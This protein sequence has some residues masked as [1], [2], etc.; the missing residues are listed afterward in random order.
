MPGKEDLMF[1]KT[2]YGVIRYSSIN[3]GDEIQSLAQMRFLPQID[4]YVA[5]EC[6]NEFKPE[7]ENERVKL[8]M[9]AW[10]MWRYKNFPPSEYIDP[11]FVSFHLREAIRHKFL[12]PDTLEYLKKHAP[13][14]CRDTGTVEY[15]KENGIDAYFTGCLT[16]TLLPNQNLKGK[17]TS[18]YVICVDCPDEIVKMVRHRTDRPVYEF[19]RMLSPAFTSIDRFRLAKFALFLYHNAYCV[20][21]P[22]LHVALPSIAFGVPVCVI[23][24]DLLKRNGR[25]D[26]LEGLCNEVDAA[27][28]MLSKSA[29]D[30]DNPPAN[31][32]AY[33]DMRAN[34][35]AKCREFTKFDSEKSPLEDDY[36]PLMDM[37]SLLAYDKKIVDR[38]LM[39]AEEKDL[40]N[41]LNE[42]VV[43]KK[44]KFD[45]E[46]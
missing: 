27:K 18:D 42:K 44:S 43:N 33:L 30:I 39:F 41:A 19:S 36:N 9:N 15:F 23:K 20:V 8:I 14:G 4:Y 3:I 6:I 32:D 5:R 25:F 29:Y 1:E 7:K 13:I 12:K 35:V 28:F 40:L 31:P 21:T 38:L 24:S 37:I 46:Y 26:G 11:L 16:T 45:L 34:L 10:W 22:R 17:F 2:K